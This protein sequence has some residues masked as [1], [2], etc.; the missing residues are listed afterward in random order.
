MS[1]QF[2]GKVILGRE[3]SFTGKEAKTLLDIISVQMMRYR[4]RTTY[5]DIYGARAIDSRCATVLLRSLLYFTSILIQPTPE[6]D[7]SVIYGDACLE[8][9]FL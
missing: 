1:P 2:P 4:C 7:P 5:F 9:S 6:V 8:V 3:G